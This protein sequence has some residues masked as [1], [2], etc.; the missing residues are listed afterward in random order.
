MSDE[1]SRG[2][3][4]TGTTHVANLQRASP[5]FNSLPLATLPLPRIS[6]D[7]SGRG[8]AAEEP[9]REHPGRG[10]HHGAEEEGRAGKLERRGG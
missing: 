4:E 1:Y 2:P 3:D 9:E 6:G 8:N 10:V 5:M 7:R